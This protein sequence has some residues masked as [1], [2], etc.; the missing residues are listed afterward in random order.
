M[1]PHRV[2]YEPDWAAVIGATARQRGH[3]GRFAQAA[4][5]AGSRVCYAAAATTE[6]AAGRCP[7]PA[8]ELWRATSQTCTRVQGLA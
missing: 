1:V 7:R 5:R 4:G 6:K 8:V 3:R 2:W